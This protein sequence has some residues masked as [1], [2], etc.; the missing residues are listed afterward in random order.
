MPKISITLDNSA[1]IVRK[2]DQVAHALN[3]LDYGIKV[4]IVDDAIKEAAKIPVRVAKQRNRKFI[5]RTGRLRRTIRVVTKRKYG[6]KFHNIEAG[7]VR[8]V[9]HAFWLEEG[10]GLRVAN[11]YR[12]GTPLRRRRISLQDDYGKIGAR[13]FISS[14]IQ[15]SRRGMLNVMVKFSR[16]R[17]A[18]AT[19]LARRTTG[20]KK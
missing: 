13:K 19:R 9:G 8:G 7:G 12:F 17:L 11:H 10:T 5:D 3:R 20:L 2:M 14:A 4:K 6:R 18:E 16:S 15:E 1:N